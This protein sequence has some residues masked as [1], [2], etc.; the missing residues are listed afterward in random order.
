M[1]KSPFDA[2]REQLFLEPSTSSRPSETIAN[3]QAVEDVK[4]STVEGV[5][6][7]A[8]QED[9]AAAAT[10][11]QAL[12]RRYIVRSRTPLIHL[13]KIY[14]VKEKFGKLREKVE[15]PLYMESISVHYMEY[16]KFMDE[17][18]DPLLFDL[19]ALQVFPITC[20]T[21]L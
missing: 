21:S 3:R 2:L 8:V 10:K 9:K 16:R 6:S 17:L 15:D 5:G 11:I 18:F 13:S 14:S 1:A 19:D 20:I 4:S 7:S 12:V